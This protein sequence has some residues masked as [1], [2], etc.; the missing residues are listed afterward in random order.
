MERTPE[1][2]DKIERYLNNTL[3]E[4]E[5]INF[6]KEIAEHPA[7]AE[8][9]EKHRTLHTILSDT[10]TLIFKEKLGNISARIKE[11]EKARKSRLIF[12]KIAASI[13]V[14]LGLGSFFW[15]ANTSTHNK[16][17]EL[18]LAYYQPFLTEDVTRGDSDATLQHIMQH[19]ANK[20]YDSV[21]NGLQGYNNLAKQK[22]L[23]LYLGISYLST[24]QEKKALSL[25]QNIQDSST[26]HEIALWYQALTY[27]KLNQSKKTKQLLKQIIQYDG[28]Y[29][30]KATDL[31][32][33]MSE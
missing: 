7:L 25:F 22:R 11:E 29:K 21:I 5:F 33:R 27:L 31:L 20:H 13:A 26:Y 17:Q 6:E 24:N 15:Y 9:V 12:W 14:I 32:K 18:Y 3:P 23:Q 30:I 16:N 28:T 4:D 10:D 19:Y 1:I 2:F 8:E